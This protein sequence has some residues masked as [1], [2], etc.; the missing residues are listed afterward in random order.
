MGPVLTLDNWNSIIQQVNALAGSPP[1]G[2]NAVAPLQQVTDPH[3]WSKTDIQ[4][5]QQ[6]LQNICSSDTFDSP[7]PDLWKQKTIDDILAA[8][9]NG[10]CNCQQLSEVAY[11]VV[12]IHGCEKYDCQNLPPD[13]PYWPTYVQG[14]TNLS[15]QI[16]NACNLY[17]QAHDAWCAAKAQ[18]AT[19]QSKY[20]PDQNL[21]NS[22]Q[23]TVNAKQT[24]MTTQS[25]TADNLANAQNNL[26]LNYP[27]AGTSESGVK[28][29]WFM[30]MNLTPR[31]WINRP[32]GQ[33]NWMG[34]NWTLGYQPNGAGAFTYCCNG[35]FT[36]NGIP[37]LGMWGSSAPLSATVAVW[38]CDGPGGA[39]CD[40]DPD[41]SWFP[42]YA[43]RNMCWIAE[44]TTQMD[45][46]T[47]WQIVERYYAN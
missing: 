33:F 35:Y 19:A 28:N 1:A 26:C 10:W 38:C 37:F 42:P 14:G 39:G 45:G 13:P 44:N 21:I 12:K 40:A 20:P 15:S 22:L 32:C 16:L 31:K 47:T 18:L 8:I 29:M 41:Y 24:D 3:L 7:I 23:A 9:Q 34:N 4:Q 2:C 46:Y 5:V 30:V 43:P 25:T 17:A 11:Q 36:P 6:T 27:I